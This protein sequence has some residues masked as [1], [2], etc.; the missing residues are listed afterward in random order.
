MQKKDK[1][2]LDREKE[3]KDLLLEY[4]RMQNDVLKRIFKNTAD[5]EEEK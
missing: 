4:I 3:E 1:D 5:K 2:E